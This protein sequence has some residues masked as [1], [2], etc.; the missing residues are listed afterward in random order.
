MVGWAAGA[1]RA[2]PPFR[3]VAPD[4]SPRL[5]LI[6]KPG[7]DVVAL[8]LA[9][10]RA[11]SDGADV[12]VCATYIEGSWSPMLD[13]ALAFA[14]RLGRGGLGA[15]VVLPTG[16]ETSSPPGSVHASL[17][18]SFGDPAT[19]PR[20]LCVAPA[21]RAG[22]WFFYRDRKRLA[23]PFANRGP[24][25]RLLAPGDDIAW[26]LG[27]G[28]RLCHAE[29]SGASAIA[30]GVALLVIANNPTLRLREIFAV[31]ETTLRDVPPAV[32]AEQ[33]PFADP[34]DTRPPGRDRDGHNAK[35]GYG[36]LHAERACLAAADPVSWALVR[37][38]D[39]EAARAYAALRLADPS[40]RAAYSTDLA[41]WIV[42]A[43]LADARASHAIRALVRHARLLAADP[44]RARAFPPGAF[45]RQ[46]ALFLRGLA[47]GSA[48]GR[49]ARARSEIRA[50]LARLA[51]GATRF[52]DTWLAIA[53]RVFGAPPNSAPL[54]R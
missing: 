9:I 50:C 53:R 29:S 35:H 41:R 17:S 32:D 33:G 44:R 8:A 27:D 5:Y 19:D 4:T 36:A 3:G 51:R 2:S 40:L 46:L 39:L 25:V 16:R 6:P 43:L 23:R 37:T 42:R 31:L 12:V 24:S 49:P 47:E 13:D 52:E 45:A 7:T 20:V 22:G 14:E 11:V 38:G 30:A 48:I 10:V 1:A 15:V 54:P 18:L 34:H 28:G 26:P 21:A